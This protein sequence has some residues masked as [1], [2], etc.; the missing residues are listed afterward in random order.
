[1]TAISIDHATPRA[2]RRAGDAMAAWMLVCVVAVSVVVLGLLAVAVWLGF[3][4]VLSVLLPFRP[5]LLQAF[6]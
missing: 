1:M 2:S 3:G 5:L 4:S 6:P